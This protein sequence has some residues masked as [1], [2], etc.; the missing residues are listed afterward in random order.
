[1]TVVFPVMKE[2]VRLQSGGSMMK[3]VYLLFAL[4]AFGL[5]GCQ[6]I[7][8]ESA[9]ATVT[10]MEKTTHEMSAS[11]LSAPFEVIQIIIDFA[12]GIWT[13]PHRHGGPILVTLL[14]GELTVR[15]EESGTETVYKAGDF[16][17]EEPGHMIAAGNEGE[18]N[19]RLVATVLLPEGAEA[20]TI[21]EG[22]N[23]DDLPP[24]PTDVYEARMSMNESLGNFEAIQT[25][26]DFA[27]GIWTP[28]HRHGGPILVT[29]LEG[30]LTV[31]LEESGTETVYKAGDF[32]IEEPGHMI[33]AGNEGEENA[34][35][36]ATVLLPEGAEAT[37]IKEGVNTDNLPPGPTDVYEA[38][39]PITQETGE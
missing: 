3:R 5:L 18:E 33:A 9:D 12:P 37:T 34:R 16:W 8:P 26:M 27:P 23:T 25:T 31:R 11:T 35:L 24:G 39:M 32:W 21:K 29:L 38:R 1:M 7:Q 15:L 17:I 2:F 36:V 20:T 10:S 14:E 4:M 6:P 13:P 30:E 22:V 19:A 28:P